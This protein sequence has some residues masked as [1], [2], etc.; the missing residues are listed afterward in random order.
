MS[1]AWARKTLMLKSAAEAATISI[2]TLPSGSRCRE[3]WLGETV[4]KWR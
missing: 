3:G 1:N 2:M 4:R